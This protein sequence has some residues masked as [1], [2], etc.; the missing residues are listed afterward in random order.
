MTNKWLPNLLRQKEL[1]DTIKADGARF[2]LPLNLT[3]R[4]KIYLTK[5]GD[6]IN[7]FRDLTFLFHRGEPLYWQLLRLYLK[8]ELHT[9][10]P[11]EVLPPFDTPQFCS[12]SMAA[13]L[14]G[15]HDTVTYCQSF[16]VSQNR[17][18]A[19]AKCTGELLERY[20]LAEPQEVIFNKAQKY[21]LAESKNLKNYY[22]V[23]AALFS[24][25]QIKNNSQL[26]FAENKKISWVKTKNLTTGQDTLVPLQLIYWCESKKIQKEEFIMQ[27]T[28]SS[29]GC[30]HY[31]RARAIIGA[32]NESIERDSFL[33]HWLSGIPAP[34]LIVGEKLSPELQQLIEYVTKYHYRLR[35]IDL[36]N[37]FSVPSILCIAYDE[38]SEGEPYVAIGAGTGFNTEKALTTAIEEA[39]S[40][41]AFNN[42]KK[43]RFILP[44]NFKP[45][46]TDIGRKERLNMWAGKELIK[47]LDNIL[48]GKEKKSMANFLAQTRTFKNEEEELEIIL[49][50]LKSFGPEYDVYMHEIYSPIL[51]RLGYYVV[52]VIIPALIPLYL[53][54][55]YAP[56]ESLRLKKYLLRN[57][58]TANDIKSYPHLFP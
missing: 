46:L 57:G 49:E 51:K 23:P 5:L 4:I 35:F 19:L 39:I 11:F 58:K 33:I 12:Y 8:R 28:T 41:S 50:K 20:F 53:T 44:E 27:E 6:K 10:G 14:K 47:K 2:R 42:N 13:P 43:S 18:T 54:E 38:S 25:E 16:G 26:V 9:N 17:E 32:I 37:E 34:E 29:G 21:S 36:T 24:S 7:Y 15:H 55:K 45:F 52:K 56:I 3:D 22:P 31:S 30:G 48:F 1:L 40:V